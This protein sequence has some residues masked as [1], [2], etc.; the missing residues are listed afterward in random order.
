MG[1][2]SIISWFRNSEPSP[3]QAFLQEDELDFLTDQLFKNAR[4]KVI[5][6]EH[7]IDR[8]RK[9]LIDR[10]SAVSNES[11]NVYLQ[12]QDSLPASSLGSKPSR[13]DT[14]KV[15]QTVLERGDDVF[16]LTQSERAICLASERKHVSAWERKQKESVVTS[17]RHLAD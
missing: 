9:L 16:R 17:S 12:E 2:T 13:Q 14:G 8:L 11:F 1:M 6:I 10:G 15:L 5:D 3:T 7:R 4:R